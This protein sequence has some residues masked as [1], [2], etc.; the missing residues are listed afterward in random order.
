MNII[1][2]LMS[3]LTIFYLNQKLISTVTDLSQIEDDEHSKLMP[4]LYIQN[5]F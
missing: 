3:Y 2:I 4:N 5:E 1:N